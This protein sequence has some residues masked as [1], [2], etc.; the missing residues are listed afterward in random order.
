MI[1][2]QAILTLIAI[3]KTVGSGQKPKRFM[4]R[5]SRVMSILQQNDQRN[6]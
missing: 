4:S 5:L 3:R 1:T 2:K 6:T